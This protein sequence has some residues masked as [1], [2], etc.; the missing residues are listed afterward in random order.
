MMKKLFLKTEILDNKAVQNFGLTHELLMENAAL[1]L[2]NFVRKKHKKGAKIL[3]VCGGGNNGADV[4]AAIRM[5]KGD[6]KVRLFLTTTKLK[7][8]TE[9]QLKIAKNLGVKIT[10]KISKADCVIDGIFGSGLNRNLEQNHQ[11]IIKKLN[12][13]NAHKIACDVPSGLSQNGE[14]LGACFKADDTICMGG[15]KLGCFSDVAKDFVGRVRRANL[16]VSAKKFQGKTDSFL[17]TKSDL[18]LPFR[19]KNCVNKGDFGHAFIIGG[20][21]SGASHI[22][23]TSALKMG[24]GLVSIIGKSYKNEIMSSDKI[25]PK[26]NAGAVGMGL[27]NDDITG[28]SFEILSQ[29]RLV[30]DASLCKNE[31]VSKLLGLKNSIITPHPSEF[32]TLLKIA[33]I[34]DID[35]KTLQK[36]RF[37]YARQWSLRFKGVLVLKGAN[38]IIAKNGKI[39]IMPFGSPCLAKGGSGDVLSGLCVSLLAQ[40]Y[41]PL[42]AAIT[43]TLAHALAVKKHKNSYAITPKDIIKGVECLSKR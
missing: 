24:A 9:F 6:Y 7:P 16:G 13:L 38:T 28:L 2:A 23:A 37:F 32:C 40:G 14:I 15:L 20:A 19:N 35:V 36:N 1:N 25:S 10:K 31:L 3:G 11:K 8:L 5:L 26:M 17:L 12:R 29:K 33:K 21:M 39:Y 41:K 34:A 42:K 22:A 18:K 27:S 43:A 30:I 4:I